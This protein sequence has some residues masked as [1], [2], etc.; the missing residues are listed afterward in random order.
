MIDL[1]Q[2]TARVVAIAKEAGTFIRQEAERFTTS[3]I[4]YKGLNNL[5][6][7]VDKAAEEL[8][9]ERLTECLPDA[10]FITEE[11]TI[12]A[13]GEVFN[14]VVD[15]LDGTT[16]F[17]HG[18]PTYSVSIAL[19][20]NGELVVGVVYEINRDECFYA[21]QGGGAYLN[22][23]RISVSHNDE[24]SKSLL[25]T[26]FPYYDFEKLDRFLAVFR[27][28]TQV[29]HGI[30]RVGSAAVDLAYVACGRYEGYFEYNLNSYDMAAGIVLVR[31]AGGVTVNFSGGNEF[32]SAREVVATNP[33]IAGKLLEVIQRHF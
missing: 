29:T 16:N 12:N 8:I 22:G 18:L 6:S 33:E 20:Q 15:P 3:S 5:V 11:D 17:I 31:E 21:W 19:E 13:A 24:L 10:G 25:A 26:G 28:L 27:E 2:M 9:V 1:E 7:Y 30:R 4:E 14:W 23:K 32:F